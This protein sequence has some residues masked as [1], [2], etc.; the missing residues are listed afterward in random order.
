MP[1]RPT[2]SRRRHPPPAPPAA[3]DT[4]TAA[5]E[6][7]ADAPGTSDDAGFDVSATSHRLEQ[8]HSLSRDDPDP[9]LDALDP[10]PPAG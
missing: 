3:D 5:P 6:A 10:V 8:E 4:E 9:D 7:D 2:R 1:Q